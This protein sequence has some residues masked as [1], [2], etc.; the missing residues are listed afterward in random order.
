MIKISSSQSVYVH[1]SFYLHENGEKR[2]NEKSI[3]KHGTEQNAE[4]GMVCA[5]T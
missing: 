3:W 4:N 1:E 5:L 2:G